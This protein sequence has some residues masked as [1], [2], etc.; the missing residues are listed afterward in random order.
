M[1]CIFIVVGT[2]PILL[3]LG[4]IKPSNADP[5]VPAWVMICAGVLFIVAGLTVILDYGMAGGLGPDGDLRPGTSF[6]IR[7]ANFVL[8]MM[9][10]GLMTAVFG[11]VAFGSGPR[12]FSSTLSLPFMTRHSMGDEWSGRV[13][14]GTAT[15]AMVAMFGY[16][17]LI[18]IDRFRRARSGH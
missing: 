4:I 5:T 11:W 8:G 15:V 9:L 1:G 16:C 18:G 12:R 10:L 3:G 14:F 17:G 13:I 6:T 7:L 2:L